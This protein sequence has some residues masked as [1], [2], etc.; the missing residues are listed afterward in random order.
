MSISPTD[1]FASRGHQH[2]NKDSYSEH[3]WC[4]D[5]SKRI[6]WMIPTAFDEPLRPFCG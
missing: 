4:S 5:K 2:L 1:G 6:Q 3:D